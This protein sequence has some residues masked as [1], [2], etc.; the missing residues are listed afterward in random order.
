MMLS[1]TV[2]IAWAKSRCPYIDDT[3]QGA[4]VERQQTAEDQPAAAR[5]S[6]LCSERPAASQVP[7]RTPRLVG[8]PA[9]DGYTSGK[10]PLLRAVT[11]RPTVEAELFP[12][13]D[14]AYGINQRA[15]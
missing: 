2:I 9:K 6:C 4:R 12:P 11:P 3:F 8:R 1:I 15:K 13:A 10:D 7:R 5:C 14:R